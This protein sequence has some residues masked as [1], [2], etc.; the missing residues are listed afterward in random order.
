MIIHEEPFTHNGRTYSIQ[1]S[2]ASTG[3][4]FSPPSGE[5]ILRLEVKTQENAIIYSGTISNLVAYGIYKR[6]NVKPVSYLVDEGK[7]FITDTD[8]G[9]NVRDWRTDAL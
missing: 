4:M 1:I 9:A 5:D 2:R 6:W 3:S 8:G 7:S